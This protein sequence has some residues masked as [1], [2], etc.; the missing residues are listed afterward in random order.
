MLLLKTI[1]GK[2]QLKKS[3]RNRLFQYN[4]EKDDVIDNENSDTDEN[5]ISVSDMDKIC[6]IFLGEASEDST[7]ENVNFLSDSYL[8]NTEKKMP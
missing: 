6:D 1:T 8:E 4:H 3:R 2:Y 5:D 7:R